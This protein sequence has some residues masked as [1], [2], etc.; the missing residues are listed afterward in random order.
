MVVKN[1][2]ITVDEIRAMN[3]LGVMVGPGPGTPEDSGIALDAV[4]RLGPE[5]GVF[6]VCMGHQCI[7]QVF[8]GTIIRAPCGLMH[9]KSSKVWHTEDTETAKTVL[10]GL[11]SPFLAARYHSLVI[12]RDETFPDDQLEITAWTED[13]T[14]MAVR[15]RRYPKIQGVQFHP[16]SIITESGLTIIA[17]WVE[18]IRGEDDA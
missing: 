3:P 11:P 12:A 6:G 7:G 4:R 9:G 17:N 16:E 15:H 1:D 5:F 18:L 2:Q 10:A 13:E 14:I 8:G